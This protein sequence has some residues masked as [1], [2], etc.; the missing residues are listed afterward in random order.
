MISHKNKDSQTE[1]LGRGEGYAEGG[2]ASPHLIPVSHALPL[3]TV[4]ISLQR[5]SHRSFAMPPC[6]HPTDRLLTLQLCRAVERHQAD[7]DEEQ[8]NLK[9]EKDG[10][11]DSIRSTKKQLK[12]LIENAITDMD[13]EV[14]LASKDGRTRLNHIFSRVAE[15]FD[16][17]RAEVVK[18]WD[19]LKPLKTKGKQIRQLEACLTELSDVG[20]QQRSVVDRLHRRYSE[21]VL[22]VKG[23]V[24]KN[25]NMITQIERHL[26]HLGMDGADVPDSLFGRAEQLSLKAENC[27]LSDDAN[28]LRR[29]V[30]EV[31]E[32]PSQA[33]KRERLRQEFRRQT[34]RRNALVDKLT[35][36]RVQAVAKETVAAVETDAGDTSHDEAEDGQWDVNVLQS[37][38][39]LLL[40]ACGVLEEKIR[41]SALASECTKLRVELIKRDAAIERLKS[42]WT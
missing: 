5:I 40:D 4:E 31:M 6:H 25:Q 20:E 3:G 27:K 22:P 7:L 30:D 8:R 16:K 23:Q 11:I 34:E 26:R 2:A 21:S 33:K 39:T 14:I 17:A 18:L 42:Q 10:I 28:Q 36:M 24:T 13:L 32:G 41:D 9:G 38:C 19:Q 15:R 29:D 1:R 35:Q 12:A 37:R